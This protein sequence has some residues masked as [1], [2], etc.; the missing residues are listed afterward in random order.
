[1]LSISTCSLVSLA[2]AN[3]ALAKLVVITIVLD[4]RRPDPTELRL[5]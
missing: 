1:M 3:L 4:L 2:I 5:A